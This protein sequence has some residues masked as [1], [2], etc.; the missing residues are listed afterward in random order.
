[1][2]QSKEKIMDPN[3]GNDRRGNDRRQENIPVS[4]DNDKRKGG[5][6]E[7]KERRDTN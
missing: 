4:H 1:M 7:G 5:R 2:L 3:R 6:R